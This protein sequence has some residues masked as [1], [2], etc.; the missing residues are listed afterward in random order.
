MVGAPGSVGA[1]TGFAEVLQGENSS[2]P[3]LAKFQAL[4]EGGL[5]ER[6]HD[7]ALQ[8]GAQAVALGPRTPAAAVILARW[9]RRIR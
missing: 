4:A 6:E 1:L 5:S 8:E 3:P 7:L 2:L 9:A